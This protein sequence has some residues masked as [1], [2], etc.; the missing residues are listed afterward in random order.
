MHPGTIT[1]FAIYLAA[2]L[3]V[4][5]IF[6]RRTSTIEDYLLGGRSLNKWVTALSAQ[7]SDMSGWLLLGLPGAVFLH[8]LGETWIALG[9]ALGTWLNWR[10]VAPSLRTATRQVG[11]ITLPSFF[12]KKFGEPYGAIG[13]VSALVVFFFFTVYSASGLKASGLLF[14]SVLGVN[15]EAAVWIGSCVI[16]TYTVMGGFMAVCWTDLVQGLMILCALLVVPTV[17][18][19]EVGG[20]SGIEAAMTAKGVSNE[21]FPGQGAAGVL[22]VISAASWGLGYFGQPH[23]LARFMAARSEEDIPRSRL[24]AMTWVLLALSGAV[25]VGLVGIAWFPEGLDHHE[26]VFIH[27]VDQIFNPWIGGVLLAAILAAIMS[28]IDSQLL[29]S[30]SAVTEDLY[31]RLFRRNASQR[32]LVWVGRIAVMAITVIAALIAMDRENTVLGLVKYAWGGLGASFGPVV[33]LTLFWKGTNR[34]GA[35][36]G[37]VAGAT[38]TVVWSAAGLGEHLYE[39][40]PGFIAG[41]LAVVAGSKSV[42]RGYPAPP[43]KDSTRYRCG[44]EE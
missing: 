1:T 18:F 2:M 19:V 36:A 42:G 24:I 9:L 34:R 22:A 5:A 11:A 29:V 21:L 20:M 25:L 43:H 33:L 30:S 15:Y 10:F 28:T 37:L 3:V 31:A 14:E 32:E 44:K 7:A 16:L 13:I 12:E 4:G 35:L 39:I 26:R 8:G 38:V 23:I 41:C 17:A 27:M 40:V 6:Y